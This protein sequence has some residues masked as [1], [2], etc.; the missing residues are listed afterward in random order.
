M[1][2][3]RQIACYA[4]EV[5]GDW[6]KIAEK[7]KNNDAVKSFNIEENYI[8]IVDELYPSKLRE[9]RFPPWILFYEGDISLLNQRCVG[10]VGSRNSLDYGTYVTR[11]IASTLAN[12]YVLVSGLAK[13]IDAIVHKAGI[14]SGKTIGVLGCG[15]AIEYPMCNSYLYKEMRENH[16]LISEYPHF[17]RPQ[18]WHFPWRNRI[19]AALSEKC[20][21]TQAKI[22]SGTMLTV[23]EALNLNKD[24]YCVPY[25]ITEVEGEGCNLLIQQGAQIIVSVDYL[26][27]M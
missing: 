10:I 11:I 5:N 1:K 17:V 27:E 19:I 16:L 25:P 21:V 12:K 15:L 24:I 6:D 4:Y 3:S 9:L 22:N 2:L 7:I 14:K 18:K 23:N 20:I 26:S 13:G 8:T